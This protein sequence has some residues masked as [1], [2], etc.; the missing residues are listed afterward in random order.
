MKLSEA[1]NQYVGKRFRIKQAQRGYFRPYVIDGEIG[2]CTNIEA[3]WFEI[4]GKRKYIFRFRIDIP[5][6]VKWFS[7]KEIEPVRE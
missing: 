3:Y 4:D 5:G 1:R 6:H 7:V 2:I